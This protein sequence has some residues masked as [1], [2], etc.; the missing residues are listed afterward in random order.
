MTKV[1]TAVSRSFGGSAVAVI[2]VERK[3]IVRRNAGKDKV[4]ILR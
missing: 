1:E 3:R 4:Y 2:V